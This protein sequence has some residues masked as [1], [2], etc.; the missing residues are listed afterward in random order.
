MSHVEFRVSGTGCPHCGRLLTASKSLITHPEP[1]CEL[2]AGRNVTPR[3][4]IG[5]C[6]AVVTQVR[7]RI[8]GASDELRLLVRNFNACDESFLTRFTVAEL[9]TLHRA[10]M[11]SSH[12]IRPDQ[13][14]ERQVLEALA[15]KVPE[16]N[17]DESPRHSSLIPPRGAR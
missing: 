8:V 2:F 1:V 12:D 6:S 15:G 13:W 11:A 10:W 7:D 3:D 4:A 17:E 16:W 14:S 9:V 5:R